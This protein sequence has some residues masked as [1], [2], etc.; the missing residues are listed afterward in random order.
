M[1]V[2]Q[3]EAAISIGRYGGHERTEINLSSLKQKSAIYF[4]EP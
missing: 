1:L 3:S 2:P 4:K